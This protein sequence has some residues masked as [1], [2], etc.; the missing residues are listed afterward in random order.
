[1]ITTYHGI[2]GGCPEGGGP[3]G[4]PDRIH[5]GLMGWAKHGV[6]PGSFVT[7]CLV[8]DFMEAC[9][10]ADDETVLCLRDIAKFIYNELPSP[11]HGSNEAVREWRER[12]E[13]RRQVEVAP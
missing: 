10:R 9:C 6:L 2:D 11:C 13:K 3:Y 1:V 5:A 8:N 4:M 12:C 7:A